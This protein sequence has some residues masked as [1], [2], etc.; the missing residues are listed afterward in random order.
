MKQKRKLFHINIFNISYIKRIPFRQDI[1]GLRAIAVLAVVFYHAEIDIFKGGWLGVDIFFVISGY[2]ISNII[3]SEL[4]NGTFSFKKF[5]LRRLK[6]ILPALFSMLLITY[7]LAFML[8]TPKAINEYFNSLLASVFFYANYY[9]QNLDLYISEAGKF[10]PLLHTWSLAIEEQYYLLFPIVT[11][12]VFK[13]CQK[14]FTLIFTIIFF[15]SIFVNSLTVS[16]IKFYQLHYRVWELL[17]GVLIMIIGN[18]IKILHLEKIGVPFMLFPIFYFD[19]N[20][21]Y[22]I[23]PKV[24]SLAGVALIIFSNTEK[25]FLSKIL[26]FKIFGLIGISSYSIYLLHQP[27]FAF[28]R[29]AVQNSEMSLAAYGAYNPGI[30]DN[31]FLF[32]NELKYIKL[33]LFLFLILISYSMY[34]LVEKKFINMKFSNSYKIIFAVLLGTLSIYSYLIKEEYKEYPTSELKLYSE[35]QVMSSEVCWDQTPN[36]NCLKGSTDRIIYF[37]GD[38]MMGK[39]AEEFPNKITTSYDY[40]YFYNINPYGVDFFN[41]YYFEYKNNCP[42]CLKKFLNIEAKTK[43]IIFNAR[44]PHYL[45]D[46]Y[47]SNGNYEFKKKISRLYSGEKFIKDM[48]ELIEFSDIFILIYP[49]PEQGW[50]TRALILEKKRLYP[51]SES[52]LMYKKSSGTFILWKQICY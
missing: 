32:F 36:K 39:I 23:E 35:E 24:L 43:I 34:L 30:I 41:T 52:I 13:Y 51:E 4:N 18:N 8:F 46:S 31:F 21:I 9:F 42:N 14:Y 22:D 33:S 28:Y 12:F 5:Y 20:W 27:L 26:K 44:L 10:M 17:L 15:G 40:S 1:N 48:N 19:D 38:S 29:V 16:T 25:T 50:N 45:N 7:P 49:I 11:Y 47:F 3:I 6:R 2:L 37:I